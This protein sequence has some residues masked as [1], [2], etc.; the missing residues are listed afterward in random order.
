[1]IRVILIIIIRVV[2]VI[3]VCRTPSGLGV[4]EQGLTSRAR[5][6]R[7]RAGPV[8]A[9][10][11]TMIVGLAGVIAGPGPGLGWRPGGLTVT[12]GAAV[13]AGDRAQLQVQRA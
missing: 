3:R 5:P 6:G 9:S 10:I 7:C 8:R 11:I 13:A 12:A 2:R 4:R 1:M